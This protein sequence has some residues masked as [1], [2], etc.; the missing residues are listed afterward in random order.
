[1]YVRGVNCNG[2]TNIKNSI[3]KEKSQV[4]DKSNRANTFVIP[5]LCFLHLL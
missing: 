3:E 2:N 4:V 1:M 5:L